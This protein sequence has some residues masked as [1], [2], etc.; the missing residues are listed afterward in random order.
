MGK[1]VIVMLAAGLLA[2]FGLAACGDDDGDNGGS[3]SAD[4]DQ[5]TQAVQAVATSGD[6]SACTQY[7]TAAFTQQVNGEPGQ[8]AAEA[9]K[10]CQQGAA[11]TVGDSVDVSEV[12]VDGD[13]ATAQAAVN[14]GTFGGQTLDI[15]LV[16]EG[17]QWK[18]DEFRGFAEFD[19]D[20]LVDGIKQELSSDSSVPPQAVDCVVGQLD[21]QS[22]DQLEALY[23]G[24]NPNAEEQI[25]GPCAQFFRG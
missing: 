1:R 21:K 20:A 16:K 23:T 18:L 25:F 17:G 2:T 22:D 15:A 13:K 9:V 5:I 3:S 12:E 24:A 6:P 7:Q 10:S 8:S 4:E 14:G 19:R 11:D